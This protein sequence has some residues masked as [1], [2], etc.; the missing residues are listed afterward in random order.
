MFSGRGPA[1]MTTATVDSYVNLKP[2]TGAG[3]G[4]GARGAV[5]VIVVIVLLIVAGVVI[6]LVR[7]GRAQVVEA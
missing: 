6:W 1:W 7:R 4:G 3:G 2:V 5:V